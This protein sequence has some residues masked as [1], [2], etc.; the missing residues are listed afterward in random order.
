MK[1]RIENN[2]KKKRPMILKSSFL[3]MLNGTGDAAQW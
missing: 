3:K 1:E 2:N